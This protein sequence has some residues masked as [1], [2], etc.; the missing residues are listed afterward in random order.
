MLPALQQT[1]HKN[2][3]FYKLATSYKFATGTFVGAGYEFG[4]FGSSTG[5][6]DLKQDDWTLS[7]ARTSAQLP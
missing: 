1:G 2:V 5:G 6:A 3:N 7:L 4:R